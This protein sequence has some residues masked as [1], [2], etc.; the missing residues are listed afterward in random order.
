MKRIILH[1]PKKRSKAP[2]KIPTHK[3]PKGLFLYRLNTSS[4]SLY[5][6]PH[7]KSLDK[8]LDKKHIF[9]A[10]GLSPLMRHYDR[11]SLSQKDKTTLSLH[12]NLAKNSSF[13]L[14]R[15]LLKSLK[16]IIKCAHFSSYSH[17]SDIALL[18][19]ARFPIGVD[20]EIV[21]S[22]DFK[23]H[24][25]FCFNPFERDFVAN[26]PNPLH[27]FYHIWTLKES[28]IKLKNL[29]FSDLG[30]VGLDKKGAFCEAQSKTSENIK[31]DCQESRKKNCNK[32]KNKIY[33]RFCFITRLYKCQKA[34]IT[35]CY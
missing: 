20:M 31:K 23:P 16:D 4:A 13:I 35:I 17:K 21:K 34:I 30:C 8:F 24:L 7:Y 11:H 32:E 22:R 6:H 28:L 27:Y 25:D 9:L 15:A 1:T 2:H 29:K 12:P 33:H 3:I 18:V 5:P 26:S 19:F 14:S 10:L